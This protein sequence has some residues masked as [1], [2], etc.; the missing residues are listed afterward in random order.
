MLCQ[1]LRRWHNIEPALVQGALETGLIAG[2]KQ[3]RGPWIYFLQPHTDFAGVLLYERILQQLSRLDSL[4]N[5]IYVAKDHT[6]LSCEW[7]LQRSR[8]MLIPVLS[9]SGRPT[10]TSSQSGRIDTLSTPITVIFTS[11]R[12]AFVVGALN[13]LN[14]ENWL[15]KSDTALV[16]GHQIKNKAEI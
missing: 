2:H 14:N 13:I 11:R 5:N 12:T 9:E 10:N 1:R 4:I 15:T 7:G 16:S 8:F 3:Y 6:P